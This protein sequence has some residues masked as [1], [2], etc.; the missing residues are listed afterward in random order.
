MVHSTM[1]AGGSYSEQKA[2]E[3]FLGRDMTV[4][5]Y[6]ELAHEWAKGIVHSDADARGYGTAVNF[7][8]VMEHR[9]IVM[10]TSEN[11]DIRKA[12]ASNAIEVFKGALLN[13]RGKRCL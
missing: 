3:L 5:K 10:A 7:R 2:E 13:P 6:G 11:P 4:D 12:V 9:L 8:A 1:S